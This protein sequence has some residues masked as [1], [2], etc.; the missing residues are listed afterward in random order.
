VA[1][2]PREPR[3]LHGGTASLT[4]HE[5]ISAQVQ[6]GFRLLFDLRWIEAKC[7]EDEGAPC[8]ER[9]GLTSLG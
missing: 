2:I 7:E 1:H 3:R 6:P 4:R 8:P 9:Q 5:A